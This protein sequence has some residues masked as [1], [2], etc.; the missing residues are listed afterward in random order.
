MKS[1]AKLPQARMD[2]LS[3]TRVGTETLV[4]DPER[5]M[6]HRLGE[7]ATAIWRLMDGS[8]DVFALAEDA[9]AEL[10]RFVSPQSA[11]TALQEVGHLG[12]LQNESQGKAKLSRRILIGGAVGAATTSSFIPASARSTGR[13]AE[14]DLIPANSEVEVSEDASLETDADLLPNE[15]TPSD[16]PGDA[17]LDDSWTA[18]PQP[19]PEFQEPA[20]SFINVDSSVEVEVTIDD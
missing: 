11:E 3:I 14:P 19:E 6:I 1:H 20:D 16:L 2:G 9:S 15:D 8:R 17:D 4:Y 18:P 5:Y 13:E 10:E 7:E 12:L